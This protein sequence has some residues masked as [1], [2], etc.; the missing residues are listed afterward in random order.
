MW[1]TIGISIKE[2]E[3]NVLA[4]SA[5]CSYLS[6]KRQEQ[7]PLLTSDQREALKPLIGVAIGEVALK[8]GGQAEA[9]G[10]NELVTIRVPGGDESR[11][12]I[13]EA[14]TLRVMQMVNVGYDNRASDEYGKQV[15]MVCAIARS[16]MAKSERRSRIKPSAY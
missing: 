5:L 12:A 15:E 6:Q 4:L 8:V 9:E 13:E 16:S 2:I 14:I 11:S 1:T 3:K 7:T 10:E